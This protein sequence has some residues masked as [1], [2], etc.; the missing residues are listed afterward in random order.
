MFDKTT[1]PPVSITP[2]RKRP[3]THAVYQ[4]VEA[5]GQQYKMKVG[6]GWSSRDGSEVHY[7]VTI[8]GEFEVTRLQSRAPTYH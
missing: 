8:H 6:S 4:L 2:S 5:D 7:L 1:P 3:P